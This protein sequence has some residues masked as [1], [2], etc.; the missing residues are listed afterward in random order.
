MEYMDAPFQYAIGRTSSETREMWEFYYATWLAGRER[1]NDAIKRLSGNRMGLA[2][3]LL[4]RLLKLNGDLSGAWKAMEGINEKWVQ[5]H[6][7]VVVERDKLLRAMGPQMMAERERWLSAV[8]A[9]ADEWIIERKVQL[10]ID[11]KQAQQAKDL[12]LGTRFQKV[13]QTYTRTGLWM[14][15]CGQLGTSA[16]PIPPQLGEDQLARFGAYREYE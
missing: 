12:L 3:V 15:I 5:L 11:K 10:L 13:H 16:F 4:A 6:P 9:L 2:K 1:S 7:Q 8:D 14:Q